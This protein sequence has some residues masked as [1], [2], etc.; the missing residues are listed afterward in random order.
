M[1]CYACTHDAHTFS[2]PLLPPQV[3]FYLRPTDGKQ[4]ASSAPSQALSRSDRQL[5]AALPYAQRKAKA[6]AKRE[7]SAGAAATAA[8]SPALQPSASARS[9]TASHI[10][11][12]QSSKQEAVGK[13]AWDIKSAPAAPLVPAVGTTAA[14]AGQAAGQAAG[15]AGGLGEAGCAPR[16]LSEAAGWELVTEGLTPSASTRPS[17]TYEEVQAAGRSLE[18]AGGSLVCLQLM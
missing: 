13:Q 6:P 9:A 17:E 12:T 3:P 2:P 7:S 4:A 15:A 14:A 11:D 1:L 16:A 10:E 18:E 5:L 8:P